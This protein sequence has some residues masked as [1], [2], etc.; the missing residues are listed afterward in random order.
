MMAAG[1]EKAIPAKDRTKVL[2]VKKE[3]QAIAKADLA[4]NPEAIKG[5]GKTN[6]VRA[7]MDQRPTFGTSAVGKAA[8]KANNAVSNIMAW[9]D[10]RYKR[11]YYLQAMGSFL[12]ARGVDVSKGIEN[13]DTGVME[14]ARKYAS[15]EALRNTFNDFS[16]TAKALND[17]A[18]KNAGAN[19]VVEGL[20]PFKKTPMNILKRGL[21]FSPIGLAEG[22][23]Y[24]AYRLSKGEITSSEFVQ[25]LA[26]GIEGTGVAALGALL[27]SLGVLTGYLDPD[28]PE[29]QL[30]IQ[31]GEQSYSIRMGDKSYSIDWLTPMAMP[32]FV[33]TQAAELMSGETP[34]SVAAWVDMITSVADPMFNLSMLDGVNTAISDA[35]NSPSTPIQT[36]VTSA[37]LNYVSQYVPTLFGQAARIADPTRRRLY[38]DKNSPWASNIQ[39]ALQRVAN[40]IP[41][42][43]MTREPWLDVWGEP[44]VERNA[45]IRVFENLMSPGYINRISEDT[46]EYEVRR[47][48]EVTGTEGV[49]NKAAGK[50]FSVD[51]ETIKLT[52]PQYTTFQRTRGE[53]A[54]QLIGALM[55][56]EE[57]QSWD[58]GMRAQT[59]MSA[60]TIAN[61]VGKKAVD[62]NAGITG[63]QADVARSLRTGDTASA[64]RG[65][66]D[67]ANEVEL[68]RQATVFREAIYEAID[69]GADA[70]ALMA[71]EAFIE[72]KIEGGRSA[73]QARADI[74]SSVTSRYKQTYRD[75]F[76]DGD[77]DTMRSLEAMLLGLGLGY[78]FGDFTGWLED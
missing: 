49:V 55:Q 41:G 72:S 32:L 60:Y 24:E 51:G 68:T 62:S 57:Y 27:G 47:L 19:L 54:K 28:D 59:V 48:F 75:A 31:A 46:V 64:I 10:S 40:K 39:I 13:I 11:H 35:A 25:R 43:S 56:D 16:A 45:A 58:D 52:S 70:D 14:D 53:T 38:S 2:H 34:T 42:V 37:G 50:S 36:M 63:W 18:H 71:T 3:Y 69:A 1:L 33:G 15:D 44:D 8:D 67:H 29:D 9:S 76:A 77:L 7:L 61:S 74:R 66:I 4:N 12:Q 5:S 30:R 21:E 22:V 78:D 6:E 65:I 23:T 17:L 73:T 20:M 26:S